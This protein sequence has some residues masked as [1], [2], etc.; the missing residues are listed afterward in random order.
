MAATPGW[1]VAGACV[2]MR[3][4]QTLSALR[5]SPPGAHAGEVERRR[6]RKAAKRRASV[7]LDEDFADEFEPF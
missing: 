4:E 6:R 5:R 1:L 2:R 7:S 3:R